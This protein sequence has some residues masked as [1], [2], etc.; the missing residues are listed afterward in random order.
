MVDSDRSISSDL[1]R[2]AKSAQF[3]ALTWSKARQSRKQLKLAARQCFSPTSGY[4]ATQESYY[5]TALYR[6]E[7]LK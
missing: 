2:P 7:Y 4:V 1:P 5:C 6:I 3:Q